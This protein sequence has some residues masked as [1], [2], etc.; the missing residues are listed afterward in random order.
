MV[1][2]EVGRQPC[3]SNSL[4][5][6]IPRRK[7]LYLQCNAL[8]PEGPYSQ[9]SPALPLAWE[10]PL[11]WGAQCGCQYKHALII[12][13]CCTIGPITIV[14]THR[15]AETYRTESTRECKNSSKVL[16]VKFL[17]ADT[18]YICRC[19]HT[20]Y[21]SLFMSRSCVY[22]LL[23]SVSNGLRSNQTDSLIFK[24]T[25]RCFTLVGNALDCRF[26]S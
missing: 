5:S 24:E 13:V 10:L 14:Q 8:N 6:I 19:T 26:I 17:Y 18:I 11:E 12:N 3:P 20:N 25:G 15:H 2:V 9:S 4:P 1:C 16:N 7:G 23:I 22:I 21:T